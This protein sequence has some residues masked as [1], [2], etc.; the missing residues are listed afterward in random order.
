MV[1]EAILPLNV[2]DRVN[3]LMSKL[4]PLGCP[5]TG[6]QFIVAAVAPPPTL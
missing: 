5:L 1:S 6:S 3:V 4:I 2:P